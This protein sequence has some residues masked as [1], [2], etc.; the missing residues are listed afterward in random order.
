M[1]WASPE[2][3]KTRIPT[4]ASDI[5]GLGCVFVEIL[6]CNVPYHGRKNDDVSQMIAAGISPMIEEND[7][8]SHVAVCLQ[9]I[10]SNATIDFERIS[11]LLKTACTENTGSL[12]LQENSL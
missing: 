4:F 7:W 2:L 12:D 8:P 3:F 1:R 6:T 10:F 9:E 11:S 5:W